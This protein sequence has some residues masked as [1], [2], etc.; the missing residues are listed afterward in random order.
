MNIPL[1]LKQYIAAQKQ[2]VVSYSG[3]AARAN[4]ISDGT[5]FILINKLTKEIVFETNV[6]GVKKSI[7]IEL[8]T[9]ILKQIIRIIFQNGCRIIGVSNGNL[10]FEEGEFDETIVLN[11]Q[12]AHNLGIEFR[13]GFESVNEDI[14]D[15][16]IDISDIYD[17][18]QLQ[19]ER[20]EEVE[21]FVSMM[22][23]TITLTDS[24]ELGIKHGFKFN[25]ITIQMIIKVSRRLFAIQ[26]KII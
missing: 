1:E 16:Q 17:N 22:N 11:E 15:L 24:A 20:I 14:S 18:E 10:A 4:S 6:N 2:N 5:N 12:F 7:R 23:N 3:V 19:L 21:Q 9:G 25:C 26:I 8:E 13:N